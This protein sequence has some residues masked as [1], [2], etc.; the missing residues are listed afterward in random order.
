MRKRMLNLVL[1]AALVCTM[2]PA[3]AV[4]AKEQP[5]PSGGGGSSPGERCGHIGCVG[6]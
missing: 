1:S 3:G 4:Q 5:D 6:V 2:A